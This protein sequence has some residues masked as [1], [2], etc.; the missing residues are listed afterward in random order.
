MSERDAESFWQS[1][2]GILGRIGL[3]ADDVRLG[4]FNN[5]MKVY[6]TA[7]GVTDFQVSGEISENSC[8]WCI[9]HVGQIYHRGM[10]MPYLPKHPNCVHYYDVARVGA[11]PE[12]LEGLLTWLFS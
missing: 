10:F 2:N 4:T 6:A 5:A 11:Q 7:V 3:L 1:E 9:L 12:T 8:D